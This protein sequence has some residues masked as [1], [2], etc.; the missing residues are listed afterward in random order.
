MRTK[1]NQLLGWEQQRQPESAIH[2]YRNDNA[3]DNVT[4]I[5]CTK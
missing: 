2:E 5:K 3:N 1:S 4:S